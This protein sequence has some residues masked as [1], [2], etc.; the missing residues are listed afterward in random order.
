MQTRTVEVTASTDAPA[1][2]VW[3]LLANVETWSD[4]ADFDVAELE[5]PGAPDPQGV[6][7]LRRFR[8][9]R[10]RNVEEVVR[11]EPPHALSYEV[12]RSS[13]P[14]RDYHAE[15]VLSTRLD[16]GTVIAWRSR[17]RAR[18]PLARL[19]DRRLHAF[20]ADT[21]ERLAAEAERSRR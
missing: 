6:G 3:A 1:E 17:F 16:G 7:A 14:M 12:R 2:A 18:W 11:F 5:R 19:I 13:I 21:A 10:V 8:R 20:I 4:W 15:V 9:G